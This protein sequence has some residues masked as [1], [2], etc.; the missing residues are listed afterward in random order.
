VHV[1]D[2]FTLTVLRHAH[3]VNG[4]ISPRFDETNL[5][6]RLELALALARPTLEPVR[7]K[8]GPSTRPADLARRLEAR[9]LKRSA[10]MKYYGMDLDRG[11]PRLAPPAG[12][13]IYLVEDYDALLY[14]PHPF[15][16]KKASPRKRSLLAAFSRLARET[17]R[18]LFAFA[19]ELHGGFAAM[20]VIYIHGEVVVGYDFVVLQALRRQGIGAAML[21]HMGDFAIQAGARR[22]ALLSST[23]GLKFYPHFGFQPVGVYPTFTY[24][25]EMQKKEAARPALAAD[26]NPER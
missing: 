14:Q 22:A 6:A 13:R 11:L 15:Y 2:D 4:I 16:G 23:Q 25:V 7:F 9:G 20:A 21:L 18:R 24:S 10:S 17:P 8:L 3:G 1:E 12:L 19:A 5:E 26:R